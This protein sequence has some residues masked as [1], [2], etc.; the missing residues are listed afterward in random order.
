M[1]ERIFL[2]YTEL[3]QVYVHIPGV[4]VHKLVYDVTFWLNSFPAEDDVYDRLIPRAMITGQS[5]EFT[6]HCL[7]EF[8]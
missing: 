2:V 6:K 5:V 7:P 1:K 4:L 8:G 3:I